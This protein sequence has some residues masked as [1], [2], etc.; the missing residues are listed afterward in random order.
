MLADFNNIWQY[1]SRENLYPTDIFLSYNVQFVYEY[2]RIEKRESFRMLSM[3]KIKT[4]ATIKHEKK[5]QHFQQF[6]QSLQ[7]PTFI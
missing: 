3:Q 4:N 1:C 6:V 2:Y 5:P 7:S